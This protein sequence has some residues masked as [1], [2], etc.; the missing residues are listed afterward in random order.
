MSLR[1]TDNIVSDNA[2]PQVVTDTVPVNTTAQYKYV[3]LYNV[4]DTANEALGASAIDCY[5]LE[6]KGAAALDKVDITAYLDKI[7]THDVCLTCLF[8][9]VSADFVNRV[10][11]AKY[12]R[13]VFILS[14]KYRRTITSGDAPRIVELIETE[15]EEHPARVLLS[16]TTRATSMDVDR[17][18]TNVDASTEDSFQCRVDIFAPNDYYD[19]VKPAGHIVAQLVTEKILCY[20]SPSYKSNVATAQD[21]T[22]LVFG[23]ESYGANR[24]SVLNEMLVGM[25]GIQIE[26]MVGQRGRIIKEHNRELAR[27]RFNR[28]KREIEAI[29]GASAKDSSVEKTKGFAIYSCDLIDDVR[30]CAQNFLDYRTE[31]QFVLIYYL[32]FINGAN[33]YVCEFVGNPQVTKVVSELYFGATHTETGQNII[34]ANILRKLLPWA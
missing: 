10:L 2:A 15:Q 33:N 26:D 11:K 17:S 1:N 12:V 6:C 24:S 8:D 5:K 23:L 7:L 20:M 9:D 30:Q 32:S 13:H 34:S 21:G 27:M 3:L 19:F 16:K 28:S 25:K 14:D 31:Y 22:N 4:A 18:A 29:I